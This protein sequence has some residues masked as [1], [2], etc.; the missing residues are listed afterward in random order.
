MKLIVFI[1]ESI[2]IIQYIVPWKGV[3]ERMNMGFNFNRCKVQVAI[4]E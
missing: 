2:E 4:K 1:A 3:C